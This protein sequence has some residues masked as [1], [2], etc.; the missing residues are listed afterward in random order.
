[1]N[2]TYSYTPYIHKQ[3]GIELIP[4]D[5][6]ELMCDIKTGDYGF[7]ENVCAMW[8]IKWKIYNK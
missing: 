5:I 4:I 1:M 8:R 3:V 6:V 2:Y 7:S